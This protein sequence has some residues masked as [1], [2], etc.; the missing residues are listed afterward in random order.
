MK[1]IILPIL[2]V[3][4]S[5]ILVSCNNN[6]S[7]H[8]NDNNSSDTNTSENKDNEASNEIDEK[9]NTSDSAD[10]SESSNKQNKE[11]NDNK[12]QEKNN[13]SNKK[14]QST[15][16]NKS[17]LN[18][19]NSKEI[20]YARVWYQLI[21]TRNDLKG[22]KNVYVTEIP[23]GSKVNP[24]AKNS[25]IYKEKVVKLEAPMRAGGSV[26]YS[27]NG[28]GTIN[29]YN[30]IPYKWE[31]SQNSDYSQMN[32]ITKKAIEENIETVYIKPYDNKTVAKLASKIRYN[33]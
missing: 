10:N 7:E 24:Q 30:N 3:S 27:S 9:T 20:E 23:K 12:K 25:A 15:D 8:H 2:I 32:K 26:T 4:L 1:K 14:Q 29:V 22:I 18:N 11:K 21:S 6:D 17:Y 33:K 16:K 5:V 13:D 31:N 28:D 19:F